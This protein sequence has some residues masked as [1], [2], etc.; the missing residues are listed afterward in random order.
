MLSPAAS[1]PSGSLPDYAGLDLAELRG[2]S[3]HPVLG[4]VIE[5]LIARPRVAEQTVAVYMD[6]ADDPATGETLPD[7][8]GLGL[9][10]L[11]RRSDHPVLA[12]VLDGLIARPRSVERTVAVYGDSAPSPPSAVG[13]RR[14]HR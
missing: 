11:R 14:E 3:D 13:T 12:T 9:A 1:E 5:G 10:D 2:R 6:A 8:T 7:F 4:A